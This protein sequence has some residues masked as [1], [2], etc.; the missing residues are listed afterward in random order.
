M[1]NQ[2]PSL[3]PNNFAVGLF[4]FLPGQMIET[5]AVF[6]LSYFFDRYF[7]LFDSS[8]LVSRVSEDRVGSSLF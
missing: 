7:Y 3:P 5:G 2:T 1:S 8:S 6:P 4:F